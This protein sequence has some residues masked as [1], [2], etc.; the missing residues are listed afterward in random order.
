MVDF[1]RLARPGLRDLRAYDTGHDLVALR[2]SFA[3]AQ[4]VELG[5]NENPYG[6]SPKAIEAIVAG[7]PRSIPAPGDGGEPGTRP[8]ISTTC[9]G[10]RGTQVRSIASGTVAPGLRL[11]HARRLIVISATHTHEPTTTSTTPT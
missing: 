7:R 5:S 10:S 6:A 11:R 8:R 1:E 3:E 4:L 2:R 9:T